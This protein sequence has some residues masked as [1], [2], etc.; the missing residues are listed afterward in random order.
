MCP[1]LE[2]LLAMQVDLAC[3]Q[4]PINFQRPIE[5]RLRQCRFC[6][7]GATMLLGFSDVTSL[8][9]VR[10]SFLRHN[11]HIPVWYRLPQFVPMITVTRTSFSDVV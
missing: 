3:L 10:P 9:V 6:S 2:I 7:W 11:V 4:K 5:I 8:I 1:N